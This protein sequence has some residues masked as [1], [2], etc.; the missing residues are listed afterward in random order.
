MKIYKHNKVIVTIVLLTFLIVW[1]V[2]NSLL[3]NDIG[4]TDILFYYVVPMGFAALTATAYKTNI[5]YQKSKLTRTSFYVNHSILWKDVV[6]IKLIRRPLMIM[7][8]DSNNKKFFVD[9]TIVNREDLVK[10]IV[11]GI[12]THC[13]NKIV[14]NKVNIISE[15][16]S[17]RF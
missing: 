11:D 2:I 5:V 15:D 14:L 12:I 16:L 7:I 4:Y 17:K 1:P 10:N 8:K 3:I 6:D 13:D 9:F